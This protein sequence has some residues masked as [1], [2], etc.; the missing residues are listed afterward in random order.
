MNGIERKRSEKQIEADRK[1]R[2][3][4]KEQQREYF[5]RWAAAN[6]EHR[7]EYYLER[8]AKLSAL[9]RPIELK[10]NTQIAENRRSSLSQPITNEVTIELITRV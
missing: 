8:K 2:A 5:K 3:T 7:H 9:N 4:H 10:P 1:Y 6:R